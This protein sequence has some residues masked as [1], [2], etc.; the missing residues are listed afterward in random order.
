M[1]KKTFALVAGES[2][3]ACKM[4]KAESL[5]VP[6][7]DEAE[8]VP[9]LDTG[10]LPDRYCAADDPIDDVE[11]PAVAAS[12]LPAFVRLPEDHLRG[13]APFLE[14]LDRRIIGRT[15]PDDRIAGVEHGGGRCGDLLTGVLRAEIAPEFTDPLGRQL[16]PVDDQ[17]RLVAELEVDQDLL[18]L[19]HLERVD[20]RQVLDL[21]GTVDAVASRD[22]RCHSPDDQRQSGG[23][24]EAGGEEAFVGPASTRVRGRGP[25]I[26]M[27]F[28]VCGRFGNDST[29]RAV[30]HRRGCTLGSI[31]LAVGV[32][33]PFSLPGACRDRGRR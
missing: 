5:G 8:F 27:R 19:E 10:E 15:E 30:A 1:S 32:A 21:V 13:V 24:D 9:L 3:G 6:V 11:R 31:Q 33:H 14:Q 17:H 18:L 22:R 28:G 20:R 23:D 2:A 26:A 16:D 4:T 12:V 25:G 29:V 7:I